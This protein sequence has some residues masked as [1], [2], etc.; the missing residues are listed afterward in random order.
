MEA[1]ALDS[2]RVDWM[3]RATLLA[4]QHAT[5]GS[6]ATPRVPGRRCQCDSISVRRPD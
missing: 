2:V 6:E 4:V 3:R 5:S 1:P